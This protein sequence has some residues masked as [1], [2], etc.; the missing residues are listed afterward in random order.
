MVTNEVKDLEAI[1]ETIAGNAFVAQ[2]L[3]VK[4]EGQRSAAVR[5]IRNA[6]SEET[7]VEEIYKLFSSEAISQELIKAEVLMLKVKE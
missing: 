3:K 4:L 5:G 2:N 1:K 6:M 7:E